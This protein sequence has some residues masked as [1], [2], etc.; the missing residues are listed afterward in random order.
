LLVLLIGRSTRLSRYV[1]D[2]D[3]TYTAT[4]RFGA[5]SDTLDAE[6]EVTELDAPVPD[7]AGIRAALDGFTGDLLQVPPMASAVKV[8]G[9][10]LYDLHRRGTTIEREPRPVKIHSLSLTT[11]HP[12][13]KTATFEISCSSGTYV[14]S[15][16]SDLASSLETGAYLTA[17]RRTRVGTLQVKEGID[18]QALSPETLRNRI[19]HP[20][21]VVEHLPVLDVAGDEEKAVRSGRVLEAGAYSGRG[22]VRVEAGEE[23]LA[24]YRVEEGVARAE[25]VLCGGA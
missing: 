24:V 16:I 8:G 25:V 10:R 20:R 15:L 3:K 7:E 2:L 5:V 19:I 21:R 1:T 9:V 18:P 13:V 12:D 11:Y 17:L 14:R 4:A 22:S 23:L 6:G